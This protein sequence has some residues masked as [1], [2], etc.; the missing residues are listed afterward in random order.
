MRI[1]LVTGSN[2]GIGKAIC[3]ALGKTDGIHTIMAARRV[4]EAEKALEE[5]QHAGARNLEV[6]PVPLEITSEE[7]CASVRRFFEQKHGG[8]LHIL[9]NNAGFAYKGDTFG[10]EEARHTIGV[11]FLGTAK[12]TEALL[13]CLRTGRSNSN[14]DVRIINICSQAGRLGQVSPQLQ[15]RFQDPSITKADIERLCDEFISAIDSELNRGVS[16]ALS[17][18]GWPHSMY[19]ISKLAEIAYTNC[20]TTA[21]EKEGIIVNACCPGYVSTN[22]SSYKGPRTPEQG[23]ETPVW[24]ATRH[25]KV[26][27]L[28]GGFYYDKKLISW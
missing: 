17:A 18:A 22:M 26:N 19:G 4:S 5:L 1:A 15:A 2:Q 24:L 9:V 27:D 16:G 14:A 7:D 20:L 3:L 25:G 11:N 21:L 23:A 10:V 13:P 28:T 12:V 8:A 6:C